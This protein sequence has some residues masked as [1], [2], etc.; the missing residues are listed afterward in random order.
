MATNPF[1]LRTPLFDGSGSPDGPALVKKLGNIDRQWAL[2]FQSL[3]TG[4]K[5][6]DDLA[7]LLSFNEASGAG[8]LG[9]QQAQIDDL[10]RL[11]AFAG[12]S[13][14][15]QSSG[16]ATA[17]Y[18]NYAAFAAASASSYPDG[19]FFVISDTAGP[20]WKMV[21]QSQVVSG[22]PAWVYVTGRVLATQ[23]QIAGVVAAL[24]TNDLG[25]LIHC[26]DY[27]HLHLWS[28]SALSFAEGE[29]GSNYYIM[30]DSA[31]RGG[32]GW[33]V[34]D[35][36]AIDYLKGDGTVA[37]ITIRNLTGQFPKLGGGVVAP[38]AA[39]APTAGNDNAT[40][41]AAIAAGQAVSLHPHTHV[42]TLPADPVPWFGIGC[43][44]RR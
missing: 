21:Y 12:A 29:V 38:T 22:S 6:L 44:Y 5:Q 30:A 33:H 43:Y 19:S 2:F 20:T 27:E 40:G 13:E 42:I 9:Q 37:A 34:A 18:G 14:G 31:P 26:T 32:N 11:L 10:A 16:S 24:G 41:N 3:A 1:S 8:A 25:L 39:T 36:S 17:A 35:G 28:G 23:A 4:R 15:G 7:V